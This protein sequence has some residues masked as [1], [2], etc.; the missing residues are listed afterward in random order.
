M[1]TIQCRIEQ[2]QC[3]GKFQPLDQQKHLLVEGHEGTWDNTVRLTP[4]GGETITVGLVELE[5]ALN[6]IR[7]IK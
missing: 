5:K 6:V 2:R 4:H 7:Q 1:L 3:D